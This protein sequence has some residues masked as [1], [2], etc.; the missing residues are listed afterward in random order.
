MGTLLKKPLHARMQKKI[1]S[2]SQLINAYYDHAIAFCK[3]I[4]TRILFSIS[5]SS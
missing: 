4:Y 1:I 3:H 2:T 5:A